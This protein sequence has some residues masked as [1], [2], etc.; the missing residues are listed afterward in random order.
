MTKEYRVVVVGCG[1]RS[2]AHI[3][4]YQY[5]DNAK[6]VACCAPSPDR[7]D[8]LAAEFGLHAYA[9]AKEMI[10]QEKP[11]M[12]HLVTWPDTRVELM[13]LVSDMDVPLCTVEKPI[14]TGVAVW[15]A[16]CRLEATTHTKFA[17]CHQFRWQPHM[18]QC[19]QAMASGR[20]GAPKFLDISAGMN[21]AGQGT[22]TL[23]YGRALI[24]DPWVSQVTGMIYGW[25]TSDPGHPA[26]AMSE[27]YLTFENGVRGLW[28]SGAISPRTGDPGTVWQHVRTAAYAERGRV[29]FEEFGK[30]EIVSPDGVEGGDF[31]GMET[32]AQN[33]LI[34]QTNFHKAMFTWLNDDDAVP[35]TSLKQSLYEWKVVLALYTSAL[36][37]KPIE[38]DGF[39]PDIHLMFQLESALKKTK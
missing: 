8:K 18:M 30:W 17:V 22:H 3:L 23:N 14:A 5:I 24:G 12:V 15:Q 11:D 38:M 2:R 27:A 19:Q 25:D 4:P 28:T 10:K 32:W 16:L 1:G 13:T 26:P 36:Q 34:A 29:N 7:R 37:G 39:E 9:S 6:V 31:G 21:I 20:L 35:G 33:N